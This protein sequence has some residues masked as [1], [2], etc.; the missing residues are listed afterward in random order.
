MTR[1]ALIKKVSAMLDDCAQDRTW[2][3][4]EVELRD[5]QPTLLRK[6]ITERL[7]SDRGREP[8]AQQYSSR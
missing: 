8:H 7:D 3:Q 2:G 6:T 4:I 5:G 1:D